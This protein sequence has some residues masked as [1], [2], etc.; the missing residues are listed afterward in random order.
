MIYYWIIMLFIIKQITVFVL[1]VQYNCTLYIVLV[2]KLC[3]N[4]VTH[5]HLII[6]QLCVCCLLL[7]YWSTW[8]VDSLKWVPFLIR[9][10]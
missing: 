8:T 3:A 5:R 7:V 2:I 6:Y 4:S 1:Y 9:G 10:G